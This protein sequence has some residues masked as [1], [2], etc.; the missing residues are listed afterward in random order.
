MQREER[1]GAQRTPDETKARRMGRL[2]VGAAREAKRGGGLRL[3]FYTRLREPH[4]AAK[5]GPWG[6]APIGVPRARHKRLDDISEGPSPFR[7]INAPARDEVI[8]PDP[9]RYRV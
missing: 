7:P 4:S 9:N 3:T 5:H 2:P 6:H 8:A 1:R